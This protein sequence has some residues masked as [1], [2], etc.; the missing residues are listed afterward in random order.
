M[1]SVYVHVPF[2]HQKCA[3]CDFFSVPQNQQDLT[4]YVDLLQVQLDQLQA[5]VR[6]QGSVGQVFFGGGTPSLLAATEVERLLQSIDRQYGLHPQAEISLEANPETVD[7]DRLSAFRQAGVNRLSFGVQSVNDGQ[8]AQLGRGHTAQQAEAAVAMA[9]KAGFEQIGIDLIFALPGQTKEQFAA[10]LDRVI[11]WPIRHLSCYGLTFEPETPLW[12]RWQSGHLAPAS[13][14]RFAEQF[15]QTHQS[16]RAAGFNHYEISNYAR[17][18]SE[19]RHNLAYWRRTPVLGLGAGAHSFCDRGWGERWAS[20]AD[21][22][23]FEAALQRRQDPQDCLEVFNRTDA[24]AETAYLALRTR[25]GLNC[26]AFNDRFGQSVEQVFASALERLQ[27]RL[28]FENDR[29]F[30]TASDWLIYDTLIQEFLA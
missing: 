16:L 6:W 23:A 22:N 11:Q 2:C 10:E 24:M 3:Y 14:E 13:D 4:R 15:L 20:P 25:E 26:Q 8:L 28:R 7:A 12:Q 27:G 9:S 19:C 5:D 30:F 18:G 21:L 29:L 1:L 17:P